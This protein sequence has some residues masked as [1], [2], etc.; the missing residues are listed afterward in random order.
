MAGAQAAGLMAQGV[1]RAMAVNC[2]P[3]VTPNQLWA[4]AEAAHWRAKQVCQRSHANELLSAIDALG[5]LFEV[6][7]YGEAGMGN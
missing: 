5:E 7:R 1:V 4:A 3:L 6:R 2:L